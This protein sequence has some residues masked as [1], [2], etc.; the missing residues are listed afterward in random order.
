M[1]ISV[2]FSPVG[3]RI[4]TG[5]FSKGTIILRRLITVPIERDAIIGGVITND[6]ALKKAL[7][8]AWKHNMLPKKNIRLTVDGG[9]V[10]LKPLT[11]P[12]T[13]RKNLRSIISGEF[14]D[15]ENADELLIDYAVDEP[16]LADGGASVIAYAAGRKF[17][18]SYVELFSDIKCRIKSINTAQNCCISYMKLTGAAEGKTCILACADGNI[19]LLLLFVNGKYSFSSRVR[20][21]SEGG[22]REYAEE[23]CGAV[24]S[25]I[26]FHKAQRY[27]TELRDIFFCGLGEDHAE[28]FHAAE[29]SFAN[30][31]IS[32]LSIPVGCITRRGNGISAEDAESMSDYIYCLGNLISL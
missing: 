27:G 19:L 31:K 26:Q 1:D 30:Q 13:S 28:V 25:M 4:A 9:A 18:G 16:A 24:S 32:D 15:V 23:I 21:F 17:I 3:I 12:L 8:D 7:A 2:Y 6:R 5:S 10:L 20:L 11:V 29:S 22:T 14:S